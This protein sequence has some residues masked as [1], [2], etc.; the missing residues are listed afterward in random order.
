M[1][2]AEQAD[3]LSGADAA[4]A[5]VRIHLAEYE[6]IEN[7]IAQRSQ[8]QN[9]LLALNVTALG[10][11][12]SAAVA[13]GTF[14]IM[15]ALPF[16]YSFTL[17]EWAAHNRQIQKLARYV[18]EGLRPKLQLL[19]PNSGGLLEWE[20]PECPLRRGPPI[21]RM[22]AKVSLHVI[23]VGGMVIGLGGSS[24]FLCQTT[25]WTSGMNIGYWCLWGAALV[26]A[27]A[28]YWLSGL[29][30]PFRTPGSLDKGTDEESP[31][32]T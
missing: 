2:E 17:L 24:P 8:A 21:M 1:R 30:S 25:R 13:S 6:K 27:S 11:S 23:F 28:S 15:L 22:V 29:W 7:E 26:L 5:A 9:F 3:K 16:V 32:H 4:Q 19:I 12:A 18:N 10:V 20:D 14:Q 31:T